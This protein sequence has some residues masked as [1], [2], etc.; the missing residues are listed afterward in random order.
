[1]KKLLELLVPKAHLEHLEFCVAHADVSLCDYKKCIY[2]PRVDKTSCGTGSPQSCSVHRMIQS[3]Q[4]W[5]LFHK[6]QILYSLFW[7]HVDGHCRLTG[8]AQ[9]HQ[10]T[11]QV[12][13]QLATYWPL[14]I[15]SHLI[16]VTVTELYME[17]TLHKPRSSGRNLLRLLFLKCFS[18]FCKTNRSY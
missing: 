13:K 1:M 7:K 14:Y 3:V 8:I 5:N 9:C 2:R 11:Q 16:D 4:D 12:G 18:L 10:L 6:W 15:S 17:I